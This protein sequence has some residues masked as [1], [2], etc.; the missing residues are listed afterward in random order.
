MQ[1]VTPESMSTTAQPLTID[2]VEYGPVETHMRWVYDDGGRV[3]SGYKGRA[4]D[5]VCRSIAIAMQQPYQ[6][7]YNDLFERLRKSA[8]FRR[9]FVSPRNGYPHGLAKQY[10]ADQGWVWTPTAR[11][12]ARAIVRMRKSDLPKGRIIVRLTGHYAAIVD[13]VLHDTHDCTRGGQRVVY[14]YWSKPQGGSQ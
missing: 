5:C 3:A 11:I 7:V 14:G 6:Q 1:R 12:G 13:G 4:G 2:N 8:K 9:K 10:I